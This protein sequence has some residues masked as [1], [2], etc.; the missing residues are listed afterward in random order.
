MVNSWNDIGQSK[1]IGAIIIDYNIKIGGKW[2]K[3]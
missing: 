1:E 2:F 3:I